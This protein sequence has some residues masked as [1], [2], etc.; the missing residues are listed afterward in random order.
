MRITLATWGRFHFFHLA[1]Q[2]LRHQALERIYST[3]PRFKLRDEGIPADRLF[4]NGA[5]ETLLRAKER[6]GLRLPS[7]DGHLEEAKVR[8]FDR[9]VRRN[10]VQPDIHIALSGAGGVNG[11]RAQAGG[12]RYICD[13]GSTHILHADE[14]LRDEFARYGL[15]F[16]ASHPPF[17]ERELQEYEAADLITVPSTFVAETYVR[18]GI[19]R[20]KLF[21]N[22][23][24]ASLDR[25]AKV[26][27]PDPAYFTLLFV[28]AVRLRKGVGY[29]LEAFR[30]FDHPRK[31]MWVIGDILPETRALIAAHGGDDISFLGIV[32]NDRL[33]DHYS[34]ADVMVLPSIEEGL[35]LVQAEALACGCPVIATPNSGSQD[36]FE[37]GVEG[38]IVP[39]RDPAAIVQRLTQLAETPGLRGAMG[40]AGRQRIRQIGGWDSYGDRYFARCQS[41]LHPAAA[42]A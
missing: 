39:A 28:G 38:F 5:A 7:L 19:P 36:L 14:V 9:F 17:V 16:A 11:P 32:P 30:R 24:G 37:D 18:R 34:R 25:F 40:A 31:R 13:R 10:W 29:L 15:P 42:A 2:L 6:L 20:A 27:D 1:R 33:S 22:P 41:L 23:Y 26:A 21:V 8:I 3:Y 4:T 12:G 35:A